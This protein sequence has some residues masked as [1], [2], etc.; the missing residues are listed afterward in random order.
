[1]GEVAVSGCSTGHSTM[2]GIFGLAAGLWVISR[3]ENGNKYFPG[4]ILRSNDPLALK[5]V[6]YWNDPGLIIQ[7][8]FSVIN[9][10]DALANRLRSRPRSGS[11][12]FFG[13][14][15]KKISFLHAPT[16]PPRSLK[17]LGV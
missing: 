7:R 9:C 17:K 16:R 4:I 11:G 10:D 12:C 1:M 8:S 14:C 5:T 15:F 13:V 3:C 2:K 6:N